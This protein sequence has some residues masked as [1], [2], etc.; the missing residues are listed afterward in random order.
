MTVK[1]KA[2]G[3]SRLR[4]EILAMSKDMH[5]LGIMDDATYRKITMRDVN[6]AQ[7]GAV[8]AFDGR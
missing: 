7:S 3:Q 1:T 8:G 5:K 2:P 6:N 4:R